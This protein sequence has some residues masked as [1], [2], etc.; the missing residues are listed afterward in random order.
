MGLALAGAGPSAPFLL[1]AALLA[2]VL[3]PELSRAAVVASAAVAVGGLIG[4]A[5]LTA[6]DAPAVALR[7][8]DSVS[9]HAHLLQMPVPGT[10]GTSAEVELVTGTA[11]GVRLLARIPQRLRLPAGTRPGTELELSGI[12]RKVDGGTDD[13]FDFGAHLR[14][15]GVWGELA[16]EHLRSTGRH[17]GGFRGV[18]DTLRRR[19]QDGIVA[20]VAPSAGALGKGMVLGDDA[21]ISGT[22][23]DD[24]RDSGLSHLL[25]ASGSN[26]V[27]LC[28]LALPLLAVAGL[29]HGARVPVL[30]ALIALYV[31]IAG[32]G[33]SI[34][35]AGLM[36][37]ATLLAVALARPASR[38][39][40][41]GFAAAVTLVLNPRAC[42]DPGWQL[43]FAAVAGILSLAPMLRRA[44]SPLPRVVAEGISITVAATLATTPLVAHHFGAV[45]VAG[46]VAN[47][48]AL[49]LVA[50]IMWL[51]MLR[52]ALGQ[53]TGADR[54]IGDVAEAANEPLGRLLE[55]MLA[56]IER[57][58]SLFADMPGAQLQLSFD[59]GLAVVGAY[60]VLATVV[61]A[62][63]GAARRLDTSASTVVAYLRRLPRMRK[64]ALL[65]AMAMATGLVLARSLAPAPIPTNLTVTFLDVGQGDATLIQ[66][67]DGSAVLFDG[68]PPEGGA[69][70]LLRRAG[71]RRLSALVMTHAS[72]DH[73]G[74]LAEVV[75]R[76][77]V[78]LLVNGGDGSRDPTFRSV[79]ERA[80]R[81]GAR[82]IAGIAPLN[83]RAGA[84]RIEILSPPPRP[85]GPPPDDPNPRAVV[86]VVSSGGF[87][88]LLSGDAESDA[89]LPLSLPDV[90]AMKV[91]HHGS[92]D[93]GLAEV[94]GRLRPEVA[95]IPVGPNSY[96]HPAPSTL[97]ALRDAGVTT[98]R[99]DRNGTV[100]L[101]VED[102]AVAADAERGS[103]V[104]SGP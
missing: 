37:A 32:G 1:A 67:P 21:S 80:R 53:A 63:A 58:A 88:L 51:G 87:D 92:S 94:L 83:L 46:L 17:R 39:Y 43:S 70:R 16:I 23:R 25:A 59:S 4:A 52:A 33:P 76:F 50:P 28:A 78:D 7:A 54:P 10:F 56:G 72:R 20:G 36:G 85:L 55:P 103:A 35:R 62:L 14:R 19:A 79:V 9:G 2:V 12:A 71:V 95:S 99:N 24:F 104:T 48:V 66:H 90:D 40:A 22:V 13:G 61:T 5:R 41:L 86:A 44:L 29:S 102:G 47:V 3:R 75:E 8:G 57:L 68:G 26:V 38:W 98:W 82:T 100:R 91:P 97:T 45:P 64:L 84:L 101:T 81:G 31:P 96:G 15:R 49:P 6:I 65:A 77:P 69:A 34:Q 60:V 89:L 18:L 93:P 11:A 27:L 42:G 73:H 74:G 30:L